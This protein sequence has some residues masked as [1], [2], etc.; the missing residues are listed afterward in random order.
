MQMTVI[1]CSSAEKF[2]LTS[3]SFTIYG[4]FLIIRPVSYAVVCYGWLNLCKCAYVF[5][6]SAILRY[7]NSCR[8]QFISTKTFMAFLC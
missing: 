8:N 5:C 3:Y 6:A 1:F 4:D 7:C 2:L